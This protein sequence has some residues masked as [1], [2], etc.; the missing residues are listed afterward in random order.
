MEDIIF[1]IFYGFGTLICIHIHL[2]IEII[3]I[4]KSYPEPT[5]L[6]HIQFDV[7]NIVV[8]EKGELHQQ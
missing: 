8:V 7:L 1:Y 2:T 4:K 6:V 5:Q 3:Q